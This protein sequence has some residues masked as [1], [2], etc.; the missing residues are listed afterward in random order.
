MVAPD[1]DAR[2]FDADRQAVERLRVEIVGHARNDEVEPRGE[3]LARQRVGRVDANVDLDARRRG[4]HP[5][6]RRRDDFHRRS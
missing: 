1:D 3:Q 2:L 6:H 5:L 4:A